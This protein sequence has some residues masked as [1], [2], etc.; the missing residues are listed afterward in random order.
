MTRV[1]RWRL[2]R[3]GRNGTSSN[4]AWLGRHL[5]YEQMTLPVG[6][7]PIDPAIIAITFNE[8]TQ[9]GRNTCTCLP[10]CILDL[11]TN[12]VVYGQG[13]VLRLV[14]CRAGLTLRR[15][16]SAP[17]RNKTSAGPAR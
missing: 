7:S 6:S 4:T 12:I 17:D 1:L 5:A 11:P 14:L 8:T 16:T 13:Q 3:S 9:K 15:L 10:P 2:L